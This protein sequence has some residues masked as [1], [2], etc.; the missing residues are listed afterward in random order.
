V[1][2]SARAAL[3]VG[4]LGVVFGDIGTSPIY[5]M[6]T[7][8]TADN[9]AVGTSQADVYGIIS[10]V[11]WAIVL[12]VTIKYLTFI[13]RADNGGEGGIMALTALLQAQR[14]RTTR[15]K[16]I[17]VTLGLIGASLF[18][19][20]GVITPAISV[21]SAVEGLH[22]AAPALSSLVLPISL[23]ILT[24][25]F[26]IQRFGTGFIG[27]LF[28]PVMCL[29]FVV[30]GVVGGAQVARDPGVLK[31]LSPSYG[32]Q[33]LVDHGVVGFIALASV[34]LVI[35][36]AEALYADMGHFGAGPI[37]RA[38]FLL[39]F[40]ALTLTY[41]GQAALILRSPA[42]VENP[43]YLILP[44]WA[45]IP[46]V[47]LATIATVIAS[48]AVI[49]GAF[50]VARQAVQLGVL[51]RLTI[52]HTSH[53][54]EG[55]LYVPAINWALFAAV[56]ALVLGFESSA[57]LANAYGV[58]VTATFIL[59]T[60]LFLAVA[61]VIW[62]KPLWV[63]AVAAIVFLTIEVTFF[64]ATLTK[65]VHGG[66]LPIVAGI[67]VFTVLITWQR[68]Q[69]IVTRNRTT[70]EGPLREFVDTLHAADPPI[71]RVDGTAVFL[72]ANPDTTPLALRANVEHNHALHKTVVI[73][74]I[75]FAKVP[76]VPDTE[77]LTIDDLGYADD[78]ISH[79]TARFGFQDEPL[80]PEVL[81]LAA[82]SSIE[83]VPDVDD[84]SY[85]L[86]RMTIVQ[87]PAPGMPRWQKRLFLTFA[88]NAA[89]PEE[90]FG[91]PTDRTISMGAQVTI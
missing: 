37:R 7:V 63:V 89:H 62:R 13:L 90:Y 58:A 17:L 32:L 42:A 29:W 69:R 43:F 27:K 30:L 44:G 25:L 87:T 38:W 80:I 54:E 73:V 20:D 24:V 76:H 74:S 6:Q 59:N 36:G 64:A 48:Q 21:L 71:Y 78:G 26:A 4:A 77:R 53:H 49:S 41:L 88:Q 46:M 45:R 23:A 22:V 65:I 31:G 9:H 61:R 51:P 66:W 84:A 39:A 50:S 14:F 2:G 28:G 19:G 81:R 18:F 91:L 3:T 56:V 5:A 70:A 82:T 12:V 68:G 40:P 86:S 16:V 11:F 72:N 83:A 60:I 79:I 8:F 1:P 33:F 34:V 57:G 67:L 15:A 55:Q 75:V 52:R 10:L 47:F 35:T 85:F